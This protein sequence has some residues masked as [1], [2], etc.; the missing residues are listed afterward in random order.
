L[1]SLSCAS[2]P[3]TWN[4]APP[5]LLTATTWWL[6]HHPLRCMLYSSPPVSHTAAGTTL[7]LGPVA[8]VARVKSA[9]KAMLWAAASF[10]GMVVV[11]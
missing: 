9:L 5:S 4:V 7:P 1:L 8:A 2:Y 11:G 3:V 10:V 6:P